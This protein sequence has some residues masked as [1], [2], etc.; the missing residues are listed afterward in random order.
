MAALAVIGC[1]VAISACGSSGG[2]P[3][4]ASAH[5]DFLDYSKCMRA[6]GVP[7][8]P[9]PSPGGGIHVNIGSGLNPFSPSF[10]AARN[11]CRKLLPGGGPPSGHSAQRM[12]Q[13]LAVS[14]CMRR[15]GI[16]DF[17]DPTTTPPASPNGFSLIEDEA[18]AVLAV[19]SSVDVGA[20]AFKAA[21]AACRFG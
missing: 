14:Q 20:P 10:Q 18:G 3:T 12:A 7:E 1:L 15:H 13:L 4:L 21:A 19:P 8:F 5:A 16:S 17:P 9:D 6:H 11:T 2:H